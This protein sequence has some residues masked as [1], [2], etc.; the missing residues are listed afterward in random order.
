MTAYGRWQMRGEYQR[1]YV[2]QLLR[3][4][5]DR[6]RRSTGSQNHTFADTLE[7]AV[8]YLQGKDEPD[9]GIVITEADRKR[10]GELLKE[11]EALARE[12]SK[13]TARVVAGRLEPFR[14]LWRR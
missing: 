6:Q 4:E 5:V 14:R 10:V 12:M 7:A 1:K 13:K 8:N 2:Y 3:A 9:D 11:G